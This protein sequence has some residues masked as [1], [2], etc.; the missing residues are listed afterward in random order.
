MF[1]LL[2]TYKRS[3][4]SSAFVFFGNSCSY[5]CQLLPHLKEHKKLTVLIN[6]HFCKLHMFSG[7][8][9]FYCFLSL[10]ELSLLQISS[11]R[12][13][14]PVFRS[15]TIIFSCSIPFFTNR[16]KIESTFILLLHN[17]HSII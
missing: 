11:C 9:F 5:L 4:K 13:T 14:V 1:Q 6:S 3:I 15:H 16:L 8:H 2:N 12:N 10:V 7:F 17:S